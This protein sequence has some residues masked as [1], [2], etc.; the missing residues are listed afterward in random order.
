VSN[1]T[2]QSGSP[3]HTKVDLSFYIPPD[4]KYVISE[5]FFPASLLAQYWKTETK[6]NTTKANM[7]P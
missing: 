3:T 7:H 5:M 2:L 4:T 6:S 1:K